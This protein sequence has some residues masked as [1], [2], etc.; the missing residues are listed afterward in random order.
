M[1]KLS[2]L[3]FSILA[4]FHINALAQAGEWTWM[5]G[6]SGSNDP[7]NY[8]TM[9]VADPANIPPAN[10]GPATWTDA[11]GNFWMYG[12]GY[13]G[14]SAYSALWKFDPLT[15]WWTWMHGSVPVA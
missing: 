5:T 4:F 6:S 14:L 11:D 13:D 15:G 1:K 8:G 3:L 10:Y 9:G 12:G 7:G 2:G